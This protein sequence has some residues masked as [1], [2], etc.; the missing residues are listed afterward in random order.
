MKKIV[1]ISS[2]M[3]QGNSDALCDEFQRGAQDANNV[4]ERINLREKNIKFCTAC[5]DCY[6]IGSCTIKDDMNN[7]YEI[8]KQAEILVF[9]TPIY[10][11]E[12]SGQLKVF[13]DRLYPIYQNLKVKEAYVIASC[14]QND[15]QFV[16]DSIY[17]I[18]R[19]LEDIGNV[20]LKAVIYGENTDEENDITN[21]QKQKAYQ[22]GISII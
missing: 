6:N 5:C 19:F 4:V 13:I 16:D 22:L 7:L 14:Y 10:F 9:A 21:E 2:S 12:I 20:P 15:K 3:R 17:G 8:L 1:I 11:G 18:E